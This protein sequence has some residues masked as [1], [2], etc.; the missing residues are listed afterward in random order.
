MADERNERNERND[1]IDD[2]MFLRDLTRVLGEL[3]ALKVVERVVALM[4]RQM[5]VLPYIQHLRRC[6]RA[7]MRSLTG[8]WQRACDCGLADGLIPREIVRLAERF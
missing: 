2:A 8:E 7:S 1:H 3:G 4:D 6:N 5:Q